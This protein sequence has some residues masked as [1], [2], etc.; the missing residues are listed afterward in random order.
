MISFLILSFFWFIRT[1]KVVLFWL[2]LWQLK[3]YHFGRFRDHFRT[4]KGKKL[5]FNTLILLKIFFL[6]LIVYSHILPNN[7]PTDSW[8]GFFVFSFIAL[9]FIYT[10]EVLK[11][12]KDLIQKTIIRP[13]FTKKIILLFSISIAIII[14]FFYFIIQSRLDILASLVLFDLF[15]PLIISIIVL[16]FQ[17][18][19]VLG[20]NRI[21]KKAKEK[22][23]KF[24]DLLVIG[25]TGSY[26]KTSTKEFLYT[27]LAEKFGENKV[28]KTKEHQNSEIGVSQCILNDLKSEHKIFVCEMAS[29]NKGGIKLLCDIAKP[30]IGI[31]T[32]INEQHMSTQGSQENIIKTKYE[33]I[34]NLP[35]DGLSIFNGENFYCL[36][37]YQ[38]TKKPK[39]ICSIN[40]ILGENYLIHSDFWAEDLKV[41]KEF[42]SFKIFSEDS[43]TVTLPSTQWN[44]EDSADFKVNLL[45][46]QS[47]ENILLAT[48]C[49]KELRINLKEI[50][51]ACEKIK[52]EQGAMKLIKNKDG[53]NILGSTYST[54]PNGVLSHLEYL[55]IWPGRKVIIMPCLIELG[56]ASKDV[57]RRIGQKIGEVCDLA[58]ITTKEKFKDLKEGAIEK[59]MNKENILFIESPKKIFEKIKELYHLDDIVL[60]ESRVPKEVIKLLID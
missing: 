47:V 19:A 36:E 55:K 2:Y 12:V 6:L 5:L 24:K 31:L 35:Q 16:F 9:F 50:A 23:K 18:L 60:L 58:I 13:I 43:K 30:K 11:T 44:P 29:Y 28:L 42:L 49:A 20:R 38:K 26:G 21:I 17:P 45:G 7:P 32:G 27:I 37:L 10:I 39:R 54:N 40:K 14:L 53:L 3:E 33:L 56:K 4:E 52:P 57:H 15:L 51:L 8:F 59:G 22:R 48:A 41:E 1:I 34:E 25:I 46:G